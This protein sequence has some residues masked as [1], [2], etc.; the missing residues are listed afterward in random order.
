MGYVKPSTA[1]V[2]APATI[3]TMAQLFGLVDAATDIASL[4]AS[5]RDQL[6]SIQS[7]DALDLEDVMPALEFDPRWVS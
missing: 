1:D 6:A 4:A 7:L 5:V 3:E 2:I